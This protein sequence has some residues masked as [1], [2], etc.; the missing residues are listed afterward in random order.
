MAKKRGPTKKKKEVEKPG[1]G[2][3]SP[4]VRSV[5]RASAVLIL[6]IFFCSGLC[7]L[8]YEVVWTRLLV[9]V[10]GSTTYAVA[11]VLAVFMLGLSVGSY[12]FGTIA[13]RFSH[14]QRAYGLVE[15]AIGIYAF[16]FLPEIQLVEW[17]HSV[18]FPLV[19]HSPYLLNSVRICVA[20]LA[21][22][23]P[24]FLM[25]GTI[26]LLAQVLAG[27]RWSVGRGAGMLYALN[28]LGAASGSFLS[29]FVI[30][31]HWGLHWT[32]FLGGAVN[33][34]VGVTAMFLRPPGACF[35][36]PS[37]EEK[38]D[39]TRESPSA[40]FHSRVVLSAF[41][42]TG[43]LSMVYE[44]A[45]T[46]A[47]VL[48]FG[49]SIYAF[50]TM[51]TTYLLGLGLGSL[52]S[53]WLADRVK[54][55]VF[56]YSMLLTA[57]GVSVLVTTPVLGSLPGFFVEVFGGQDRSWEYLTFL[58]FAVSFLVMF[59]PTLCN[60]AAFPLVAHILAHARPVQ[61][62]RAVADAY[63]FNT[64]GCIFGSLATG[65][66]LIPWLGV[67]KTLLWG[68]AMNM[69]LGAAL[70]L[71]RSVMPRTWVRTVTP[72]TLTVLAIVG[73]LVFPSWDRKVMTSGVYI[74]AP[75]IARAAGTNIEAYMSKY[76][77]L[78]YKDGPSE[79]VAV[80]ESP[81]GARFLR[82]NGKT[83]GSDRGD[84]YTQSLLGILPALYCPNARNSLVIG[85]GTGITLGSLLDFPVD[86]VEVLEISHAVVEASQYFRQANG[87]ALRSPRVNL[88]VLDGRTWLMSMPLRYDVVTSEPSHPWQTGNANLFT[89]EFFRLVQKRLTRDG[90]VC[91]WLPYYHMDREHFR[92][93]LK[94][95][96][97][98]FPHVHVWIANTDA[99][100]IGSAQ[101]L[102]LRCE[103]LR[104]RLQLPGIR[105]RL[106]RIGIHDLTDLL[107]FF[108][109]D[110]R[111]VLR[112]VEGVEQ[113]NSD[114]F[115]IL[116]FNA[117]KY[118][119]GKVSTAVFFDLLN[120]SYHSRMPLVCDEDLRDIHRK[121]V[122]QRAK[123]YEE[124]YIPEAVIRDMIGKAT[125]YPEG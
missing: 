25:G 89:L 38:E 13:A 98:V 73:F 100:L 120:L 125:P 63:A 10:F 80:L 113:V 86:R 69:V 7:G 8:M 4:S 53:S 123:F 2:S 26:P 65:F 15:I 40:S 23:L 78:Y 35:P 28:T 112:F 105:D 39:W 5:N 3:R 77:L 94:T 57:V 84:I 81:E 59:V 82:I 29:A 101:E 16:L 118:V 83:D 12:V 18:L 87:D 75:S 92:I 116:E 67:E 103:E 37:P 110:T 17:I 117:P 68:G 42:L 49:T 52:L 76:E 46:R 11:T 108:Y 122:V 6:A 33:I 44:N 22:L 104:S 20:G 50:A 70:L 61:I 106:E 95:F 71:P 62:G 97:M 55:P 79:T 14:P 30:I 93:L 31:P 115:P 72:A 88:R 124:W 56:A 96:Q 27:S 114:R 109:L 99:L 48:V 51:L 111:A 19:H 24:T 66:L 58:E 36:S 64:A 119:M 41:F 9:L 60:G 1:G 47:L 54:K 91:Q 85:L 90:V 121:R 43:L 74:Y 102:V 34:G 32:F 45:W 107:S 21:I